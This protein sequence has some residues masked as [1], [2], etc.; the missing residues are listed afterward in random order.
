MQLYKFRLINGCDL[1]SKD[2]D[3]DEVVKETKPAIATK[4]IDYLHFIFSYGDFLPLYT[5]YCFKD[6]Y[7]NITYDANEKII[8]IPNLYDCFIKCHTSEIDETLLHM[9]NTNNNYTLNEISN[10]IHYC[11]EDN[12]LDSWGS[13]LQLIIE[14]IIKCD[15]LDI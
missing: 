12:D 13:H 7:T 5:W 4:L 9:L 14:P 15:V 2:S 1:A 10:L 6:N 3:F 8:N 11:L